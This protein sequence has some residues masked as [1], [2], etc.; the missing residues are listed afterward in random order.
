MI[1]RILANMVAAFHGL[2]V[3]WVILGPLFAWRW[4]WIRAVHLASLWWNYSV[5]A[6]GIYCPMTHVENAFRT[7]YDH[8]TAYSN[9]F[10]LH[11]FTPILKWDL[12]IPKIAALL[13]VWTLLWTGVDRKS[14]RLN[15][16]HNPA[17]RMPSS[18]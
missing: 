6:F 1:W 4:R 16:S 10:L 14:T 5:L 3:A 7:N 2:T 11:Y 12:T 18:A 9:S 17:S 15:S 8:S 13:H